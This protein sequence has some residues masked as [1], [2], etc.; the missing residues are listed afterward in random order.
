MGRAVINEWTLRARARMKRA[1]GRKDKGL[2]GFS[3]Y[4]I[5]FEYELCTPSPL[6]VG[7]TLDV[8]HELE[9]N[10]DSSSTINILAR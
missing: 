5:L 4:R 7:K 2:K 1:K 9:I 3:K 10:E 8:Y 6:S